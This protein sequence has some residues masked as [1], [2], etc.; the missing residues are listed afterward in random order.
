MSRKGSIALVTG[1][2]GLIGSEVTGYFCKQGWTVHGVDNNMRAD[3]FGVGGD[4]RWMQRRLEDAHPGF[5]HHE[6]DIRDRARVEA[7]VLELKPALIVHAA[8]Q[9][10][11]DLAAARPFDDF[12]VDAGGIA[13]DFRIDRSKHSLF[14]A[15]K[16]AR[17]SLTSSPAIPARRRSTTWAAASRTASRS[18][19]PSS[20][21]RRSPGAKCSM[22][23]SNSTARGDRICYCSDL[24]KMKEHYP[25]WGITKSLDDVF[26]EIHA[27]TAD[28]NLA[29]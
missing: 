22:S 8:A 5:R 17:A 29:R 7:L 11:H 16:V 13:E 20:A 3:F 23:T 4:T 14:G 27:A 21:P 6:L 26:V 10:S 15:F 19:R 9:P 24:R 1:S 28:R 2:S 18:S 25:G 12:D